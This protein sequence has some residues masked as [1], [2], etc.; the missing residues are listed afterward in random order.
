MKALP[1]PI[2]LESAKRIFLSMESKVFLISAENVWP[3]RSPLSVV[4]TSKGNK[5]FTYYRSYN[6]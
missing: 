3:S 2:L 1:N 5:E 4:L 6:Y